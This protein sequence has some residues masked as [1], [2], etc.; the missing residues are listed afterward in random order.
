MSRKKSIKKS[1]EIHETYQDFDKSRITDNKMDKKSLDEMEMIP[2]TLNLVIS[3]FNTYTYETEVNVISPDGPYLI[4]TGYELISESSLDNN[5]GI[6]SCI[7]L[8]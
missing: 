5:I 2:A 3:S 1:R 8:I 6:L 7:F 4:S